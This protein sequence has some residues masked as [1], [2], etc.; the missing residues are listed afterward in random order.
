MPWLFIESNAMDR[1]AKCR[2]TITRVDLCVMRYLETKQKS[3]SEDV[4]VRSIGRYLEALCISKSQ[5][6]LSLAAMRR[7]GLVESAQFANG[8]YIGNGE[9]ASPYY[10]WKLSTLGKILLAELEWEQEDTEQEIAEYHRKEAEKKEKAAS[11][12]PR[13]TKAK[14]AKKTKKGSVKCPAT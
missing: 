5:A 6:A 4:D 1:V 14:K 2:E 8:A 9:Y 13:K 3:G 7:G 12:K 11:K 10:Y